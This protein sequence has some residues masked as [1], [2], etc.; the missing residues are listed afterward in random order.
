M[1]K[2]KK[3]SGSEN[4]SIQKLFGSLDPTKFYYVSIREHKD[5]RSIQ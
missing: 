5:N 3:I 2:S 4:E 1:N